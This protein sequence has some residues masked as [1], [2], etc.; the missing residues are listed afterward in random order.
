MAFSDLLVTL[1]LA[2]LCT[3]AVYHAND[4]C[5]SHSVRRQ[6]LK[7]L[8]GLSVTLSVTELIYFTVKF[9]SGAHLPRDMRPKMAQ[10]RQHLA[11]EY[12]LYM[13]PKGP[14]HHG[15]AS[16]ISLVGY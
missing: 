1:Q 5:R 9:Q 4:Y 3:T 13:P 14:G 11:K 6:V 16:D 15:T 7:R 10:K 2:N 8:K 12:N